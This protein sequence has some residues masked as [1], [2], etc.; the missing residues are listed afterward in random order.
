MVV[1]DATT[2]ER[3]AANLLVIGDP[4]IRFYAGAPLRTSQ[5]FQIGSLCIIDRKARYL[6]ALEQ[7]RLAHFAALASAVIEDLYENQQMLGRLNA[8]LAKGARLD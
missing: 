1:D 4:F 8:E 2:D 3:F 6:V 5:G 7:A